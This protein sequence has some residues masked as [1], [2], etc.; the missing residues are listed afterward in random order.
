ML[1]EP[2]IAT[3]VRRKDDRRSSPSSPLSLSLSDARTT[4]LSKNRL[5]LSLIRSR[6][7]RLHR[8]S[9]IKPV[10]PIYPSPWRTN[11]ENVRLL[12]YVV[13]RRAGWRAGEQA[14]RIRRSLESHSVHFTS[15]PAGADLQREVPFRPVGARINNPPSPPPFLWLNAVDSWCFLP[16][17][18]SYN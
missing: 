9:T 13:I 14:G 5:L 16:R 4:S 1:F 15:C 3:V 6:C 7:P 10:K 11:H 12:L 8:S 17:K 2:W 18:L